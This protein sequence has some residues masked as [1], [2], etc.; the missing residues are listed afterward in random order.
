MKKLSAA[1]LAILLIILT[2]GC[3]SESPRAVSVNAGEI[4]NKALANITGNYAARNFLPGEVKE[5]DLSAILQAGIRAP[6]ARNGQP[7]HFT[8][9]RENDALAK[10]IISNISDG[11]VI[12][13]IS[14]RGDG[15]T[16]NDVILDCGLAVENIYL[17]AQALG[18]GSRIYTGP[19]DTVNSKYKAGL[20][21]PEDY[22]AVALVRVGLIEQTADAVSSASGRKDA[23]GLITYK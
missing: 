8:V 18:L 5:E 16:N 3:R 11:N 23:G 14:G 10:N 7:W 21:L 9:V 2:A 17:A 6:S 20:G 1:V 15:K 22:S 4:N 12:I 19:I 13:I